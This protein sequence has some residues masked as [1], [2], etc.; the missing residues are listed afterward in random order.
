MNLIEMAIW[1]FLVMAEVIRTRNIVFLWR[2]SIVVVGFLSP[3]NLS[4]GVSFLLALITAYVVFIIAYSLAEREHKHHEHWFVGLLTTILM[5]SD[6]V[7]RGL[8]LPIIS[9]IYLGSWFT[10]ARLFA[11]RFE[12]IGVSEQV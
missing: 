5:V 3:I 6:V 12:K 8:A 11:D 1:A 9:G 7:P 4:D 10:A 2:L